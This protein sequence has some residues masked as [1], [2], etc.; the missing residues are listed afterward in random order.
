MINAKL[1]RTEHSR[2]INFN[3]IEINRNSACINTINSKI[4]KTTAE[5]MIIML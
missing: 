1:K 2:N 5:L 3:Y 4:D